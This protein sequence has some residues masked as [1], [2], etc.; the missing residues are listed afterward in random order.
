MK[1]TRYTG[2]LLVSILV[3]WSS[4]VCKDSVT[5]NSI[6]EIVFPDSNVSYGKQVEPLFLRACAIPGCH[7]RETMAAGV[8][9]ETYQ[10]ALSKPLIIIPHDT[11]NSILV[12]TLERKNG[13]PLMP[14]AYRP[15]LSLNQKEGLKRWIYDYAKNN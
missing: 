4:W 2:L 14:P 10:D 6:T 13:K 12:W 15:Q 5:D 11:V 3:A 7:D 9:F 1:T 8:S